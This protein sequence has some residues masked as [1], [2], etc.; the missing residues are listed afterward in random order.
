MYSKLVLVAR[1]FNQC[2]LSIS[3]LG[4]DI[5]KGNDINYIT[6]N[7]IIEREESKVHNMNEL[8]NM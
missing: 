2:L 6:N 8:E 3:G 1:V 5:L 4:N 7:L